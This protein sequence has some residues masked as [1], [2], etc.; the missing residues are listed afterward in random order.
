MA[1]TRRSGFSNPASGVV[2]VEAMTRKPRR[3]SHDGVAVVH[4]DRLL[5]LQPGEE[6]RVDR[7]ARRGPAVL[8]P[9]VGDFTARR[10]GQPLHPVAEA[11]HR[12]AQ[13]RGIRR[14][15]G[16]VRLVDALRTAGKD[17]ARRVPSPD[18]LGRGVR[19]K[20]DG[21]HPGVPNPSRDQLRVLAAE[22]E[23]DDRARPG[24]RRAHAALTFWR[25]ATGPASTIAGMLARIAP[26]NGATAATSGATSA[27]GACRRASLLAEPHRDH[28]AEQEHRRVRAGESPPESARAS[29]PSA[30]RTDARSPSATRG[31][32]RGSRRRPGG[33]R[34]APAPG[35]GPRETSRKRR[36]PPTPGKRDRRRSPDPGGRGSAGR[37]GRRGEM[38]MARAEP[39]GAGTS[40]P[41]RL[42]PIPRRSAPRDQRRPSVE[43]A[44]VRL[45]KST[46]IWIGVFLV[47]AAGG[48]SRPAARVGRRRMPRRPA[49]GPRRR[50][51]PRAPR[52]RCGVALPSSSSAGR[53]CGSPSPTS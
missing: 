14:R 6:L 53:R 26:A 49:P 41:G 51:P 5:G 15:P 18:L 17:D 36:R 3:R 24:L 29:A 52:P 30:R 7:E 21:E 39:P 1:Q 19:R 33:R 2:G 31:G 37:A 46:R 20:D 4:P 28:A 38:R 47:A 35:T 45:R 40:R 8:A 9:F 11:Q 43:C 23:D 25:S 48:A 32:R 16:R 22:I 44:T 27:P 10:L 12:H 50:G 13:R 34:R 42:Y